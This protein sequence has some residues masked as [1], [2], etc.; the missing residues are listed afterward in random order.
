MPSFANNGLLNLLPTGTFDW[1]SGTFG[2]TLFLKAT[3][4]PDKTDT[5]LAFIA[6]AGAV[7][8]GV[9]RQVL[10]GLLVNPDGP[11]HKSNQPA[12]TIAF[13]SPAPAD[14][15]DTLVIYI[16]GATDADR[17]IIF[18]ID[19]S[20]AGSPRTTDGNPINCVPDATALWD[21]LSA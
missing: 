12:D 3:W 9:S 15:Y 2:A 1:V 7:E 16:D 21:L 6:G 5:N 13:G 11:G 17:V 18:T 8:L 10:T 14:D 20:D 4:V 19:V